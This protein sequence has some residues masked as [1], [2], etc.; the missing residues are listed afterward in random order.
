MWT[1]TWASL[2]GLIRTP[3]T[4]FASLGEE[5]HAQI[6]AFMREI[7]GFGYSN[8]LLYPGMT[9]QPSG[10]KAVGVEESIETDFNRVS[11]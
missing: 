7:V 4:C 10:V 5:H 8:G 6:K 9:L 1:C 3:A 11:V 2:Q